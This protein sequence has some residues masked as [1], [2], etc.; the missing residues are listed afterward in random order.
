MRLESVTQCLSASR[1][2]RIAGLIF[3]FLAFAGT[4]LDLAC[5]SSSG[6]ADAERRRGEREG[7]DWQVGDE[8]VDGRAHHAALALAPR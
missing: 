5:S 1:R 2:R 4:L 8:A 3:P 7:G 6:T